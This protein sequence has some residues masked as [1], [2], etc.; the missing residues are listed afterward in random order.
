MRVVHEQRKWTVLRAYRQQAQ[1]CGPDREAIPCA[2][3][4]ECKRAAKRARL[5]RR[6]PI[7]RAENRAQQLGQSRE[8][9]HRLGLDPAGS[10]DPHSVGALGRVLEQRG[11]ADPGLADKREHAAVA[12]A[13]LRKQ[14]IERQLLVFAA[15]QHQS[16][17]TSSHPRCGRAPGARRLGRSP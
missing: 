14:P 5:R 11:L 8:R 12:L 16:I 4:A 3:R 10:Q 6:D 1:C 9:D 15:K 2:R 17:L 7:H 13:G